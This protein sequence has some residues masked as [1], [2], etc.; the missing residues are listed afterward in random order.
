[1]STATYTETATG[2]I[3]L[4]G[5]TY[6]VTT[7][8]HETFDTRTVLRGPRGGEFFLR[9]FIERNGDTGLRQV[10]SY[11]SGQPL[12]VRGNEVRVYLLGSMIEQA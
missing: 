9:P 12:R 10:I 5:T 8:T 4:A 7:W 11:K 3:T 1:M 2:T 6:E